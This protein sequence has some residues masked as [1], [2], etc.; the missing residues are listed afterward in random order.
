MSAMAENFEMRLGRLPSKSVC[1]SSVPRHLAIRRNG[2]THQ[3]L[4]LRLFGVALMF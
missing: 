3:L 2:D 4:S 1:A